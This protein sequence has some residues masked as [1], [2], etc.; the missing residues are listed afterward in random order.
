[1][2]KL[3]IGGGVLIKRGLTEGPTVARTLKAIEERWIEAGFPQGAELD[4]IVTEALSS[5]S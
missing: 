4:R 1:V 3:P 5:R 2:P